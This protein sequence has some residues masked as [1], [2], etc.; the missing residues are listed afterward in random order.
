MS[1]KTGPDDSFPKGASFSF[2]KYPPQLSCLCY[3]LD[4]LFIQCTAALKTQFAQCA[5]ARALKIWI[6][7]S[8]N[9]GRNSSRV[10]ATLNDELLEGWAPILAVILGPEA[11]YFAQWDVISLAHAHVRAFPR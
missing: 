1:S 2:V 6:S 7:V 9:P 5:A 3:H 10:V 11:M 8:E 4:I